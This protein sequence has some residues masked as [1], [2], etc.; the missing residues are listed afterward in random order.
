MSR[1]VSI[2]TAVPSCRHSQTDFA[3]FMTR[4]VPEPMASKLKVWCERSG[5]GWRHST[6]PDFSQPMEEWSFFP[7]N[8]QLD[9]APTLEQRTSWFKRE[10][11][12]LAR[13]SLEKAFRPGMQA[14]DVTHLIT[15]SCTGVTAPGLD[16]ALV[17]ELDLSPTT[18]RTAIHFMGCYAAIHAL[19]QAD[20]ICRAFPNS[21]VAIADVELCTLH[22]QTDMSPETLAVNM[23]FSDGAAAVLVAGQER[24]QGLPGVELEGFASWIEHEGINDIAFDLGSQ[25]IRTTMTREVPALVGRGIRPLMLRA[26]E[27]LGLPLDAIQ[28]W[29]LHPGG[30]KVLEVVGQSL[31]LPPEALAS[32]YRVLHDYGNM[33][34][35]TVLFVLE[36]LLRT[37][38]PQA[39]ERAFAMAFGPGLTMESAI[40]RVG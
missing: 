28:H 2:A 31:E 39:G 17:K 34:S 12:P 15:V 18:E 19:K 13:Q 11:L 38:R 8:A 6:I 32:S 25:G 14:K 24:A 23:I 36:D 35:A 27:Q 16:V 10:A 20:A 7:K 5:I 9:P 1:I 30:G 40:L 26:L 4:Y 21:L 22:F 3:A 33:S 37:R 29:V